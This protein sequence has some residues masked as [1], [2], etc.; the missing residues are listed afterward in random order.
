MKVILVIF[1]SFFSA[2][3]F[4]TKQN[5]K[6]KHNPTLISTFM[7]ITN[8]SS[9]KRLYKQPFPLIFASFS[10]YDKLFIYFVL[11]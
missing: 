10:Q 5:S 1:T 3:L 7:Q 9:F 4:K 6:K 2:G 8:L 11:L